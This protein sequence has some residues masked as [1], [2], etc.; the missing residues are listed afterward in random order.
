[1]AWQQ[2]IRSPKQ[3]LSEPRTCSFPSPNLCSVQAPRTS[4]SSQLFIRQQIIPTKSFSC[5]VT[6][7]WHAIKKVTFNKVSGLWKN[8]ENL[9]TRSEERSLSFLYWKKNLF[10]I[11]STWIKVCYT[12]QERPIKKCRRVASERGGANVSFRWPLAVN[13]SK[14]LSMA[15]SSCLFFLNEKTF[16]APVLRI[17]PI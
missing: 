9:K 17:C 3:L 13:Q 5:C 15:S 16:S 12:L 6:K 10:T 4:S 8:E 1:M 11:Q 2:G 14:L 7:A